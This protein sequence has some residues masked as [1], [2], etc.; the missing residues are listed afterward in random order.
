MDDL[1]AKVRHL[2]AQLQEKDA[3]LNQ[4]CCELTLTKQQLEG[5]DAE[6]NKLRCEL[7]QTKQQLHATEQQIATHEDYKL[8]LEQVLSNMQVQH[9]LIVAKLTQADQLV[10]TGLL[11][12]NKMR[13][14][15][16]ETF[17]DGTRTED[18]RV[19]NLVIDKEKFL[20]HD[21]PKSVP[22]LKTLQCPTQCQ[23]DSENQV[24][25]L[26]NK[27]SYFHIE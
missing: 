13:L 1:E 21:M 10:D 3:A 22:Q 25:Y 20:H 19:H 8:K 15:L 2:E 11:S 17:E 14:E 4:V 5:K 16:Q 23:G 27:L 24:N 7:I 9:E 18:T 26:R 12:Q 6:S